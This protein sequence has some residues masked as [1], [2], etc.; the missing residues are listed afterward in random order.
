MR[1]NPQK[2][3]DL[4]AFT[5][6]ILN[7]KLHFFCSVTSTNCFLNMLGIKQGKFQKFFEQ[8]KNLKLW[9][10]QQINWDINQLSLHCV[11]SVQI[12]NF[13]WSVFS[14]FWSKYRK[15]RTRKKSIFEYFSHS[16]KPCSAHMQSSANSQH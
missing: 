5:Q 8:I 14:C 6:E 3:A 1:P 11:R 9:K 12:R 16:V 10:I 15:I 7:G 4:V 2:N 13:L